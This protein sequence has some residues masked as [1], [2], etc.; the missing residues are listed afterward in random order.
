VTKSMFAKGLCALIDGQMW[1]NFVTF[2]HDLHLG[3]HLRMGKGLENEH[4]PGLGEIWAVQHTR[5]RTFG[6]D[7]GHLDACGTSY[8]RFMSTRRVW[9]VGE[10]SGR[11]GGKCGL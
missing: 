3:V 7:K 11:E 2:C 1:L 6:T 4:F 5:K 8:R 9:S 10:R